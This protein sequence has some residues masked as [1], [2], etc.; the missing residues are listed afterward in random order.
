[1]RSDNSRTSA[2][3]RYLRLITCFAPPKAKLV[4]TMEHLLC[5]LICSAY[6]CKKKW[7]LVLKAG[8]LVFLQ[9]AGELALLLMAD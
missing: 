5:R 3:T 2:R 1:M 4:T 6:T 9:L 7:M 8:F